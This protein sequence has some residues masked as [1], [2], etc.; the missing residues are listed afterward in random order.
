MVLRSDRLDGPLHR[1]LGCRLYF[2]DQRGLTA[3]RSG[4]A[5]E[6]ERLAKRAGDLCLVEN[7]VEEAE[8]PWREAMARERLADLRRFVDR[9]RLLE[10]GCSTGE[11]LLV[12]G[13][14]F[15]VCGVEADPGSARVTTGRG[16]DCRCGALVDAGFDPGSIDVAV[17]YHVIEHLRD[18]RHE[19]RELRRLLR[20]GGHLVIETPDV[21]TI[22]FRLLGARWRQII[23]DH[24]FFFSSATLTR[25]LAEEGFRVTA[26]R[27][28]GKSM[29][30]R[31]FISRI[32]RYSPRLA[33]LL[34]QAVRLVGLEG[35]SLRLNLRDVIRLHAVKTM[36]GEGATPP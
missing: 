34:G 21:E 10:I 1:C 20:P 5:A 7:H 28:V 32:R 29:S 18:P 13:S 27:H 6:M 19:L 36:P 16:V 3:A 2:V 33:A 15:D 8:R 22:W 25:L 35:R 31:L 17:L 14:C 9:G 26:S 4:V 30:V 11:F 24:L 12:A 23:P